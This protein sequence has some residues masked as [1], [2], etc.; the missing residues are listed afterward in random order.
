[1][2]PTFVTI[3]QL[4]EIAALL[5]DPGMIPLYLSRI[6]YDST[7]VSF[8]PQEIVNSREE[9]KELRESVRVESLPQGKPLFGKIDMT[10]PSIFKYI[11][12]NAKHIDVLNLYYMKHSILY[13]T[14]Y[15]LLNPKGIFYLKLDIDYLT[16]V[17]Q[18][19]QKIEP[20]RRWVYQQYL[21]FV[22][23]IVS[24]ETNPSVDY[25]RK[26]FCPPKEKLLLV[27]DGI[28]DELI[29]ANDLKLFSYP[30]RPNRFLVVGRIGAYPKNHEFLLDAIRYIKDWKDWEIDFVG[31]IQET[32]ETY[33]QNYFKHNP[34][35]QERVHF[36]GAINDRIE[37]LSLYNNSKVFCM[38]SRWESF[39]FVYAEAQYFGNYILST[40]V[41]SID[42]FVE[43][44]RGLGIVVSEAKEM[45]NA[46]QNI[47]D[48]KVPINDTFEKRVQHGER[49]RWSTIC[50]NLN[51]ELIK[52]LNNHI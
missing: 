6:G 40:P 42:D 37:L 5:K 23:D 33:I 25:V 35:L 3:L 29:E 1:M 15:K 24:A 48:G 36:I 9:L 21:R 19:S 17:R 20:L 28:D 50:K 4:S 39:G 31:P 38:S 46:M 26:R 13:G 49:F 51:E 16:F 34:Q 27:P 14:L 11:W 12:K 30:D 45:G 18:E 22:P 2:K 44:D 43:N 32:F 47:I 10:S 7:F 52:L 41:S 8:L